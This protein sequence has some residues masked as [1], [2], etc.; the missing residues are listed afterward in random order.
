MPTSKKVVA[1]KQ[2]KKSPTKASTKKVIKSKTEFKALVCAIDGECFWSHDG[3]I[4]SNLAD[5]SFAIGSM[6]DSIFLHHVNDERNDF[7]DWVEQVLGDEE[8][9]KAL[10]RS[11][12]KSQAQKIVD[13]HLSK[14]TT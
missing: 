6:D 1:K 13:L 12:K 4:L 10:R 3:Q 8:C 11:G 5:L 14:Y 2:V 9:A 7:A